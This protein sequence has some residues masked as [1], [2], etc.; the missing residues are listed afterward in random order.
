MLK[1]VSI[2]IPTNYPCFFISGLM[3]L[4]RAGALMV[5]CPLFDLLSLPEDIILTV[6]QQ[7]NV[8]PPELCRTT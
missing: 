3:G 8:A 6:L 7:P 5:D 2:G 1:L 4:S